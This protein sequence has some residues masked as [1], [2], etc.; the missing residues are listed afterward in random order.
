MQQYKRDSELT[1]R[2]TL[3]GSDFF[4]IV[5]QGQNYRVQIST[6][7]QL[8]LASQPADEDTRRYYQ[9]VPT[10]SV[11]DTL[12]EITVNGDGVAYYD[13]VSHSI[14]AATLVYAAIATP[15][16][17][18]FDGIVL[19]TL[20]D[21]YT[22]VQ[23][24]EAADP[25]TPGYNTQ[26]YLLLAWVLIDENGSQVE[27]PPQTH[28][29]N[30]DQFLDQNGPSEVSAAQVQS[31]YLKSKYFAG[32]FDLE[33]DLPQT[34]PVRSFAL[35]GTNEIAIYVYSVDSAAWVLYAAAGTSPM[36]SGV[37]RDVATFADLATL[38][39]KV[40]QENV[41]VTDA[42]GDATVDAGWAIYKYLL[43]TDT[44][45]KIG[46]QESL[47]IVANT[48]TPAA[49]GST[50]RVFIFESDLDT[51]SVEVV[52]EGDQEFTGL[53][54]DQ[55]LSSV[56]FLARLHGQAPTALADITALNTWQDSQNLTPTSRWYLQLVASYAAGED[57]QTSATLF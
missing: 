16:N 2:N 44:W 56:S 39:D 48:G 8:A 53:V 3:D 55:R 28:P 21:T 31:S 36:G 4:T 5:H 18:R 43:A 22:L 29:R 27:E 11:D 26:Q 24:V 1:L 14:A 13:N 12:R 10:Y 46:E 6:L 50:G 42:S 9:T 20:T 35:V 38:P 19:D 41:Y 45:V 57:G 25:S 54:I 34:M 52:I 7:V 37:N 51:V 30:Q 17:A 32:V 33:A 47:D 15:G 23:G 49:D 40:D